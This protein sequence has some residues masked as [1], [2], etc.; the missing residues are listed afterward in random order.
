MIS[1]ESFTRFARYSAFALLAAM[2]AGLSYWFPKITGRHM[3][4]LLGKLH[5]WG[6]LIGVYAVFGPMHFLGMFGHPRRYAEITGVDY[7]AANGAED[8]HKFVTVAAAHL[9]GIQL[10]FLINVIWSLFAG[11][12]AADNPWQATTLEWATTTPPPHDN[13]AGQ[14][15]VVFR[16]PYEYSVPNAR[17]DYAMQCNSDSMV[18]DKTEDSA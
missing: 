4:E 8:L 6:T 2:F 3:N 17:R 11:K 7:L 1:I 9:I 15:P 16:D 10:I 12:R 18:F 14:A 5:F 13:F